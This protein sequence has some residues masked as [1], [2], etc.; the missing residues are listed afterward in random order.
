MPDFYLGCEQCRQTA[1]F[2]SSGFRI[3]V[4]KAAR[5]PTIRKASFSKQT[6]HSLRGLP[7]RRTK[8]LATGSKDPGQKVNCL[9]TSSSLA[10]ATLPKNTSWHRRSKVDS[11]KAPA[12]SKTV[13]FDT[14]ETKDGAIRRM[15]RKHR[16]WNPSN[17]RLSLT[18]SQAVFNPCR[19]WDKIIDLKACSFR[20]NVRE[21]CFHNCN[22]F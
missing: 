5:L 16:H 1:A 9:S 11:F 13:L 7:T 21:V 14:L 8:R 6:V 3:N 12:L 2:H 17:L 19:T 20:A 22:S 10:L 18:F 15:T 4:S